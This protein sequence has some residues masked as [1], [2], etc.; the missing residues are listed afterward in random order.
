[1]E[2]KP[3]VV[4]YMYEIDRRKRKEILDEAV[5][6]E[7]MTP[8][9]ELRTKIYEK[10]YDSHKGQDIDHFIAGW[11]NLSYLRG[12]TK[13]FWSKRKIARARREIMDSWQMDMIGEYG[14]IGREILYE[15]LFNMSR[16]YFD[17]CRRDK[18][19]NSVFLGLGRINE[20]TLTV[21]IANEVF[22]VAYQTLADTEM[23]EDFT[24]FTRAATDAFCSE[25]DSDRDTLMNKVRHFQAAASAEDPHKKT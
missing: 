8:E 5:A 14:D 11:M 3:W 20:D 21:K 24:V 15:E 2:K 12:T 6:V 10:R 7:G 19:Y 9:N 23:T 17:L 16:L 1:M 18:G 22:D 13:N 4:Q 25:F